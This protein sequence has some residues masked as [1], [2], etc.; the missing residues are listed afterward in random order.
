MSRLSNF[1]PGPIAKAPKH[2]KIDKNVGREDPIIRD[3]RYLDSYADELCWSCGAKE[4]V[5][6]HVRYAGSGGTGIKPS[7]DF[8]F[9]ACKKC[10]DA[11]DGRTQIDGGADWI[12]RNVF[13]PMLRRRYQN[14]LAT[15]GRR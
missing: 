4:C 8:T 11:F 6:A 12:M 2:G 15:K 5:G 9:P 3:R 1:S 10:H 14:W 13:M 7:D